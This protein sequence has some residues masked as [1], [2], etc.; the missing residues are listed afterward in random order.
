MLYKNKV[1]KNMSL[2]HAKM[3]YHTLCPTDITF[4]YDDQVIAEGTASRNEGLCLHFHDGVRVQS[5][6]DPATRIC[7]S[8]GLQTL[9]CVLPEGD[10]IIHEG[11]CFS[12]Y[13]YQGQQHI[14]PNFIIPGTPAWGF[15][16]FRWDLLLAGDLRA[17]V[18]HAPSRYLVCVLMAYLASLYSLKKA[19]PESARTEPS[20]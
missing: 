20:T 18:T 14:M 5:V 4:F 19:S 1:E 10:V 17:T 13:D 9:R 7:A 3:T 12:S 15:R 11:M 6:R 2:C 16:F 8:L